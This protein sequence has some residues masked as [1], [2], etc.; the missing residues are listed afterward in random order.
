ML[1]ISVLQMK[2]VRG[3]EELFHKKYE[4]TIYQQQLMY[5]P[6]VIKKELLQTLTIFTRLS[7]NRL[8]RP[9]VASLEH[10]I[11]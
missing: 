2:Q 4:G 3:W 7:F 1:F 6:V 11:L 10:G 8:L 5:L 9:T